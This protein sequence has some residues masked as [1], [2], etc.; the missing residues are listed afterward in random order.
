M[1]KFLLLLHDDVDMMANYSPKQMEELL[2][3]HGSWADKLAKEGHLIEGEGLDEKSVRI[4]GKESV[5][6]DGNYLESKE[7]IGGFY[8]LQ[9]KDLDQAIEISKSCPC[10]LWGGTTEIRP[11]MDYGE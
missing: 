8:F 7:F 4:S 2:N 10:H 11:V 3:A 6:K 1:K 5:I 9:A